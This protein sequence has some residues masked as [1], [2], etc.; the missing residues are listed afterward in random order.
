[1]A[2]IGRAS[3]GIIV[4]SGIVL[5]ATV[6]LGIVP[7]QLVAAEPKENKEQPLAKVKPIPPATAATGPSIFLENQR[8]AKIK[9]WETKNGQPKVVLSVS[10]DT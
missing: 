7:W 3:R 10:A 4:T 1:M 2:N 8:L 9:V 6:L 5:A